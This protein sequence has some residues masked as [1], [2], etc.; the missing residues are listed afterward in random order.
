MKEPKK[1]SF[2]ADITFSVESEENLSEENAENLLRDI[3]DNSEVEDELVQKVTE[4][5][6]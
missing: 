1:Q 4:V 5:T 2:N 3:L 6:Q